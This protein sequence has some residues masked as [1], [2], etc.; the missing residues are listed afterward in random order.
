MAKMAK[1]HFNFRFW[2]IAFR[3]FVARLERQHKFFLAIQIVIAI[4]IVL[5]WFHPPH[6]GWAVAI[7]A[8][9]AATMS[10]HGDIKPRQKM[11]WMLLISGLLFVEL[12][13]ISGDRKEVDIQAAKDRS[14]ADDRFKTTIEGTRQ[15]VE[16]ASNAIR[17]VTGGDSFAYM[18]LATNDRDPNV[19]SGTF[20]GTVY[21]H[22]KYALHGIFAYWTDTKM[23]ASIESNSKLTSLQK[24][25]IIKRENSQ[26]QVH[27]NG[28]LTPSHAVGLD[29]KL[30]PSKSQAVN[31]F[32]S[33]LNGDWTELYRSRLVDGKWVRAIKIRWLHNEYPEWEDVDKNYPR[34]PTGSIDW[35]GIS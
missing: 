30:S 3:L 19:P 9:V 31:I 18:D 8:A 24:V 34:G 5:F 26:N 27:I 28:N 15:S 33:S 4:C 7:M 21:L 35:D 2:L 32:F 6:A 23:L 25:E 12:R 13:A 22:G 16:A 1:R 14:D 11:A 17:A 20:H 10:M 29:I